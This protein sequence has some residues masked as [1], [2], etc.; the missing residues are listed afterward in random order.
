METNNDDRRWSSLVIL[1]PPSPEVQNYSRP[2][3]SLLPSVLKRCRLSARAA[4]SVASRVHDQDRI[5]MN[6]NHPMNVPMQSAMSPSAICIES[7][8]MVRHRHGISSSLPL[9]GHAK[10]ARDLM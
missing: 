6:N 8:L 4:A 10:L 1:S 3:A 7:F 2:P 5:A 9:V